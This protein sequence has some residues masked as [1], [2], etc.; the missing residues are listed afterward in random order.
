MWSK[1]K[2]CFYVTWILYIL[3]LSHGTLL[4]F[5][6]LKLTVGKE[7]DVFWY[8]IFLFYLLSQCLH[9]SSFLMSVLASLEW[10]SVNRWLSKKKIIYE[11][12]FSKVNSEVETKDFKLS[13]F[14]YLIA[15]C[16][17]EMIL[18]L[19]KSYWECNKV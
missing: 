8:D 1:F 4:S 3:D 19:G 17:V 10:K 9:H 13:H 14:L 18:L 12:L 16:T 11:L 2:A 7:K 15:V 5:W 6:I